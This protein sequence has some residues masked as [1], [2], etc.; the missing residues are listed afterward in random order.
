VLSAPVAKDP[1]VARD[2]SQP[3][4]AVQEVALVE[5][6]LSVVFVPVFTVLGFAERLTVG[7]AVEVTETAAD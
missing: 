4:E 7:A 5:D 6:Q 2:P 3:P 1:L